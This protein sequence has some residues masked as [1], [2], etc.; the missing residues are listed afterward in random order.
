MNPIFEIYENNK[1]AENWPELRGFRNSQLNVDLQPIGERQLSPAWP[2]WLGARPSDPQDAPR[3]APPSARLPCPW[4]PPPARTPAPGC[5]WLPSSD[6][7][8]IGVSQGGERG[9]DRHI[10]EFIGSCT[11][12]SLGAGFLKSSLAS[13]LSRRGSAVAGTWLTA[14]AGG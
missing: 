10:S 12:Q 4:A 11:R 1:V 13:G 2:R 3:P 7:L 5:Y 14:A 9:G 8:F 6:F